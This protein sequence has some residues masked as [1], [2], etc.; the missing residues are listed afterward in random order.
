MD[1]IV[2]RANVYQGGMLAGELSV[3]D[4]DYV[5]TYDAA[6][7]SVGPAIS[8]GL[9]LRK[10][11]FVVK[12]LHPFFAGLVSEGWLLNVQSQSQRIDKNDKFGLLLANGLDL[13]GAVTITPAEVG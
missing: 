1:R 5:F 8:F 13:V 6:Y 3:I 10:E 12:E 4:A 11:P 9:P 2:K 7:L